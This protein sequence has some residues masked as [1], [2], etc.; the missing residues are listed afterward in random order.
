MEQMI[1]P[2]NGDQGYFV[3]EREKRIINVVFLEFLVN[4]HSEECGVGLD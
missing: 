4:S 3:T 1:H 2:V